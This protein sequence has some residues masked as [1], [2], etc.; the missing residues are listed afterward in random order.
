MEKGWMWSL[1]DVEVPGDGIVPKHPGSGDKCHIN[2][3]VTSLLAQSTFSHSSQPFGSPARQN[4][5]SRLCVYICR[6]ESNFTVCGKS[7]LFISL[8]GAKPQQKLQLITADCL[9]AAA[10]SQ[11]NNTSQQRRDDARANFSPPPCLCL[12]LLLSFVF[13]RACWQVWCTIGPMT[14]LTT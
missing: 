9:P 11:S 2:T 14:P 3:H 12:I 7:W 1:K 8:M 5:S 6:A 4:S 13:S 10:L